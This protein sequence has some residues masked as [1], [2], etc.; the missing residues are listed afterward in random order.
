[1]GLMRVLSPVRQTGNQTATDTGEKMNGDEDVSLALVRSAY[2]GPSRILPWLFLGDRKDS[3]CAGSL[4]LDSTR[5][6]AVLNVAGGGMPSDQYMETLKRR[7]VC[8]E[9]VRREELFAFRCLCDY[10]STDLVRDKVVRKAV[11]FVAAAKA[12]GDAVLVNCRAG[13]NRSPTVV[14]LYLM[15]EDNW[16]LAEA[17][18]HVRRIR[19]VVSPHP[20]YLA[21]LEDLDKSVFR[22]LRLPRGLLERILFLLDRRTLAS[23]KCMCRGASQ[24][25]RDAYAH[26]VPVSCAVVLQRC[27]RRVRLQH[28]VAYQRLGLRVWEDIFQREGHRLMV[29]RRALQLREEYLGLLRDRD[30]GFFSRTA[31]NE[32]LVCSCFDIG[33]LMARISACE[34]FREQV[35]RAME[36]RINKEGCCFKDTRLLPVLLEMVETVVRAETHRI[37]FLEQHS[38][39]EGRLNALRVSKS[40]LDQRFFRALNDGSI[41]LTIGTTGNA[42][43]FYVLIADEYIKHISVHHFDKRFRRVEQLHHMHRTFF[44]NVTNLLG[45]ELS[46]PFL[47]D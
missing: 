10:G 38:E 3:V 37:L 14:L 1:M 9:R 26:N 25:V 33:Y 30:D 45:R 32:E 42:L 2:A 41:A 36:L 16:S 40:E 18:A 19:P 5:I 46:S 23:V 13:V 39:L 11:A 43:A 29:W 27:W 8:S 7:S 34:R 22:L 6:A 28:A 35:R 12:R 15:T 24:W 21:Q 20:R 47:Y 17:L 4:A 44:Q 31:L